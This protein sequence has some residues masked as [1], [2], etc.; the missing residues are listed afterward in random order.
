MFKR[1]DFQFID[2]LPKDAKTARTIRHWDLAGTDEHDNPDA[3]YTA[4]VKMSLHQREDRSRYV[5]VQHVVREKIGPRD[6]RKTV[7]S[8]A[9][10]DGRR[11]RIQLNEDPG[12]AGK[13]QISSYVS[14]LAGWPVF[15]RRETGDKLLRAEP[16]AAA[17]EN[18]DVYLLRGVWTAPFIDELCLAPGRYMDQVDAASGAYNELLGR[19]PAQVIDA[20]SVSFTRSAVQH[21]G[22]M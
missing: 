2:I 17:V 4:G 15:G 20:D 7:K 13:D 5:I 21:Q 1:A 12:Q 11:I 16:L 14:D 6:V 18:H 9:E 10:D 3:A 19:R 8:T 22:M